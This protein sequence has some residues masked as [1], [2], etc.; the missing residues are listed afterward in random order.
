MSAPPPAHV[1]QHVPGMLRG[2]P[3][4]AHAAV[5][6]A[7]PLPFLDWA[8]RAYGSLPADNSVV[9]VERIEPCLVGSTGE[10]LFLSVDYARPDPALPRNLFVKFSRHFGDPFHDRRRFELES[11][12]RFYELARKR[13]FPIQ[14]PRP[15]F[16]DFEP[17]SGTGILIVERIAF[18]EAGVEPLHAKCMDHRLADPLAHYRAI[19]TTLARLAGADHAGLL[20]PEIDELLPYDLAAAIAEDPIELDQAGLRALV[21]DYARFAREVPQL[22]PAHLR[23]RDVLLR[24]EHGVLAVARHQRSIRR[25]L[26]SDPRLIALSHFNANIDNAWF[27]RQHDGSLGCGLFDWQRARR[28]NLAYALWGGLCAADPDIW[29]HE[30]DGLLALFAAEHRAAGGPSVTPAELR[31]CL[32]LYSATIGVAQ[33]LAAPAMVRGRLPQVAHA[34]GLRDPLLLASEGARCFLHV[35]TAFL[36]FWEMDGFSTQL[37]ELLAGLAEANADDD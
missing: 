32:H 23:T 19:V 11:E 14:V 36:N 3:I 26:N 4:P 16:G 9:R 30:L 10:K 34:E 29:E 12:I 27:W 13:G 25:F 6:E 17:N 33:L 22:I 21:A 28:M 20:N 1:P 35:F 18:G 8:F 5:F 2:L 15:M 31:L 24:L 7:E 37:P